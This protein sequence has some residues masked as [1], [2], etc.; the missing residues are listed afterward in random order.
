[1]YWLM[2][3]VRWIFF[4]FLSIP[5]ALRVMYFLA[6]RSTTIF[7]KIETLM[8]ELSNY[9]GNAQIQFIRKA[10]LKGGEKEDEKIYQ[11][12]VDYTLIPFLTFTMTI[13][14]RP[15]NFNYQN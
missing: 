5:N 3:S 7:F 1:M 14:T 6:G 10:T 12:L 2:I 9:K 11:Y 8:H 4:E 15:N 13:L